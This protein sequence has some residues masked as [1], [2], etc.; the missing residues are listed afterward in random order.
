MQSLEQ[1]KDLSSLPA[2][3]PEK[4][5]ECEFSFGFRILSS[6]NIQGLQLAAAG[7]LR[8]PVDSHEARRRYEM[9]RRQSQKQ[10]LKGSFHFTR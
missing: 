7:L 10:M 5:R 9:I 6:L 2:A 4:E 8:T 3:L 1:C